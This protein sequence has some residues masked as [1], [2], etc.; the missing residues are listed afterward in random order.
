MGDAQRRA[1]L[2]QVKEAKGSCSSLKKLLP[3]KCFARSRWV[4]G[5]RK[6][7]QEGPSCLSRTHGPTLNVQ[8][9]ARSS[10]GLS[11]SVV[12]WP[13]L[14]KCWGIICP[15]TSLGLQTQDSRLFLVCSC[16]PHFCLDPTFWITTASE[17]T[18]WR[19]DY[20]WIFTQCVLIVQLSFLT[21]LWEL[22]GWARK[23][24]STPFLGLVVGN[25]S[26]EGI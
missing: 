1:F 12:M 22:R 19:N 18:D 6:G 10:L 4:P 15:G 8:N 13:P 2:W 14:S 3:T 17:V 16:G 11:F 9:S 25:F 24:K 7:E 21:G 23:V 26:W 20:Q 5:Y